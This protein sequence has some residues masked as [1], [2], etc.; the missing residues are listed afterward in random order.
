MF[1]TVFFVFLSFALVQEQ[2][3]AQPSAPLQEPLFR[4]HGFCFGQQVSLER[5]K[6]DFVALKANAVIAEKE[7]SV[8]LGTACK[9]VETTLIEMQGDKW[10]EYKLIVDK[11]MQQLRIMPMTQQQAVS[12][13]QKVLARA[14]GEMESPI[15]ATLLSYHPSFQS[16]PGEEFSRGF[17]VTYRTGGHPKA[18]GVDFQ[19][20]YP[21]SWLAMEGKRP[22]VIQ[23]LYAI[24]GGMRGEL[25]TGQSRRDQV[26]VP[27]TGS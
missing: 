22:N 5:I 15:I 1:Y 11:Q 27:E 4:A 17:T 18:K 14:K 24:T 6:K 3:E 21:K 9:N 7:F 20:Q 13:V 23:F 2:S 16:N 10:H 8:T 19:L 25:K 12:F 26:V